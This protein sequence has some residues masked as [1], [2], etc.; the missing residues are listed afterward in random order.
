MRAKKEKSNA[1][2]KK[3]YLLPPPSS[4]ADYRLEPVLVD[5]RRGLGEA[6]SLSHRSSSSSSL[7]SLGHFVVVVARGGRLAVAVAAP[8]RRPGRR[9]RRHDAAVP[10]DELPERVSQG[11]QLGKG[12]QRI[13]GLCAP[14]EELGV[15]VDEGA[16]D[17]KTTFFFW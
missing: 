3:N 7:L 15:E 13:E 14:G 2:P 6:R 17:L 4:A 10:V 8:P 16:G 12:H 9:R 1:P 5:L 11:H